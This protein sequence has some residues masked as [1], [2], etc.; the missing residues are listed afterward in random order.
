MCFLIL[1]VSLAGGWV[2]DMM[3]PKLKNRGYQT[4]TLNIKKEGLFK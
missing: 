3:D 2:R 1:Q 4:E